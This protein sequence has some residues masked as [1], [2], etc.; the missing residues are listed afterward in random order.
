MSRSQRTTAAVVM[1][2]AALLLAAC[3]PGSASNPGAA[4]NPGTSDAAT[5]SEDAGSAAPVTIQYATFSANAGNEENL[6]AMIDAFEAAHPNITIDAQIFPYGDYFTTLQTAIAGGTVADT[7]ELNYESFAQYASAGALT[8]ITDLPEGVY[9]DSLLQGFQRDGEQLG[10]PLSYSDI[11]LIYNPDLFAAAGIEPPTADWTWQ[12]ETAAATAITDKANG[13]FGD[14]QP[15]G[16]NEFYKALVQAGG[17]FLS[18][19]GTTTAFNSP[20]GVA[21][22]HWLL[23]KYGT[24]MATE[25]DGLGTPDFDK[26]LF[27]AGKLAM[28]HTGIWMFGPLADTSFAWDVVPEPAG[29]G[30]EGSGMF[31]N[32]VF[33][34]KTTAHPQEAQEWLQFLTSSDETV[35]IRLD[36]AWEL[37]PVA[38][39]SKMATYLEATPPANRQA[40]LDSVANGVLPPKVVRGQEISDAFNEALTAA[41]DGSKT[42]EQALA[43]AQTTIDKLLA[44]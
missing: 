16:Y 28:W 34:S 36:A 35:Q 41:R 15:I 42:V 4:A 5:P 38:D 27:Q 14:M 33:V 26:N 3:T 13:V 44:D 19:D 29:P 20:E 18:D 30:G 23:D 10:L 31:A 39:D 11:V 7:F 43:D 25:Q 8:P 21:A 12:D 2:A 24:T 9:Q 40:V 22:A 6:Q 1:A 17:Q 32:G 37:P